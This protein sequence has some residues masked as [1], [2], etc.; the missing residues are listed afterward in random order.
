MEVKAPAVIKLFGEHAVLYGKTAVAMAIDMHAKADM[1]RDTNGLTIS[2][3]DINKSA[4]F[5]RADLKQIYDS[6]LARESVAAFIGEQPITREILPFAAIASVLS[7]RHDVILEGTVNV[8]SYVP[9]QKGLASSAACSTAFLSA[10]VKNNSIQLSD[11]DFIETA[12]IGEKIQH[13]NEGAGAIDVSTS[14]YGGFISLNGGKAKSERVNAKLDLLLVDTGPK[15]KTSEMVASVRR[16]YEADREATSSILDNI[17]SC[18]RRG[19]KVLES[20]A[21]NRLELIGA[22][23]YLNQY[24]LSCLGVSSNS[25]NKAVSMAR[26]H[27]AYGAKLTGGGGGGMMIILSKKEDN[28]LKEE[29]KEN[30]FSVSAIETSLIGS[31]SYAKKRSKSF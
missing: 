15:K 5:S 20:D 2:L 24:Y 7:F 9:M 17:D 11:Q 21:P 6:F 28:G 18:S 4:S 1:E 27:Q 10:L 8:S 16:M 13:I 23:M 22:L 31:S 12:R 3:D 29:L 25:I 19:I 30:G 26:R 14:Y